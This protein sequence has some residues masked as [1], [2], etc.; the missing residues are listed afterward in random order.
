MPVTQGKGVGHAVHDETTLDVLGT[1]ARRL[2]GLLLYAPLVPIP[3]ALAA[4]LSLG[5][6]GNEVVIDSASMLVFV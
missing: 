2:T 6:R 4:K 3:C 5:M 1:C